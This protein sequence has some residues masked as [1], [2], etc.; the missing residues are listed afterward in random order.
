MA[1]ENY[2]WIDY[3]RNKYANQKTRQFLIA[4]ETANHIEEKYKLLDSVLFLYIQDSMDIDNYL[5]KRLH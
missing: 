3:Y 5:I 4:G 2:R 1:I